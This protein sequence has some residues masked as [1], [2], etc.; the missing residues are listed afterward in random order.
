MVVLTAQELEEIVSSIDNPLSR[1]KEGMKI[2]GRGEHQNPEALGRYAE[3]YVDL[4]I[5]G[6]KQV[7]SEY[8]SSYSSDDPTSEAFR[9]L[10]KERAK[11]LARDYV[12]KRIQDFREQNPITPVSRFKGLKG[13]IEQHELSDPV[14]ELCAL[15]NEVL[16]PSYWD[17]KEIPEDRMDEVMG[18]VWG[19][20]QN[21]YSNGITDKAGKV[22]R[23]E[24]FQSR[25]AKE[26]KA[27]EIAT[28][29]LGNDIKSAWHI[30]YEK[31]KEFAEV[32][33]IDDMASLTREAIVEHLSNGRIE[34]AGLVAQEFGYAPT[35][36]DYQSVRT[37]MEGSLENLAKQG[38][39]G[40]AIKQKQ[41]LKRFDQYRTSGLNQ[42]D[43]PQV[44][45]PEG[46]GGKI[47]LADFRGKTYVRGDREQSG[48]GHERILNQFNEELRLY[49]FNADLDKHS[50]AKGGAHLSFDR[51]NGNIT[52]YDSSVDL[53]ECDKEE[54]KQLISS[55]YQDREII[56]KPAN[57]R[58][59]W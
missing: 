14:Y 20:V 12:A 57:D 1:A 46:Y 19:I 44:V 22:L 37:Q 5:Q 36:E 30:D 25:Y 48:N 10:P 21:A 55:L 32:Y 40:Q 29:I 34:Q 24:R 7:A 16:E 43:I 50:G 47:V 2:F 45:I 33:S 13:I 39:V 53:G 4:M 59:G 6:G 38:Q 58:G 56:A 52:I 18:E 11:E 35:N 23:D 27:R 51:E 17:K 9:S 42:E 8:S 31:L 26:D 54:A 15:A 41:L 49:G 28:Q 3:S